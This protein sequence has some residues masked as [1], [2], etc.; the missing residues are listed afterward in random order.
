MIKFVSH[1]RRCLMNPAHVLIKQQVHHAGPFDSDYVHLTA[2]STK[3][4]AQVVH[5]LRFEER[6]IV[7]DCADRQVDIKSDNQLFYLSSA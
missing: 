5:K 3:C 7:L 1:V 4:E 2:V 6:E